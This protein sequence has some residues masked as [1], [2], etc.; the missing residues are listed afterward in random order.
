MQYITEF[1]KIIT[2]FGFWL[3]IPAGLVAQSWFRVN[4]AWAKI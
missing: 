3:Y 2:G 1:I 4:P